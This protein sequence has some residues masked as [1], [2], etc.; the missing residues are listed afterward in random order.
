MYTTSSLFL[1]TLAQVGITHAFVNWGSDHP[2]LLEDLERQRVEK[3]ETEPK[4]VTCPNEMV[5]LSAAQGYT[6]VTGKP[7]AV[8]VHV[9]VGTQALAGAVHNVNRGRAPVLIY[10]GSSP[11]SA[12]GELK[13]SRNEW[14]H[15]MQDVH[16]QPAILRQYMRYTAQ[17]NSPAN[18][19]HLVRRALQIATSDPKGPV[20]LWGRREVMEQEIDEGLLKV[21]A[22]MLKWPSVEPCALSHSAAAI[23]AAALRQAVNPLLITSHAGRNTNVFTSLSAL[24]S[25][26]GMP[27][28]VPCPAVLNTPF[29]YALYVGVGHLAPGT[30]TT[31]LKDADVILVLDVELPW[32]PMN[33]DSNGDHE[34]PKEDARVFVI[35]GGDPLK[36]NIGMY[37]VDAEMVCRADAE[38][39]LGQI[40]EAI[41]HS[42]STEGVIIAESAIVQARTR[43]ME[44]MHSEWV[45]K[46]DKAESFPTSLTSSIPAY[47]VPQ[48]I[49]AL[50][51][52]V[53]SGTP[54]GG[55]HTLML[56]ESISN[57]PLVWSH[58]RP[59]VLGGM[60]GSGGSSLGWALGASVGAFLGGKVAEKGP[61]KQGYEL[62]ASIVGDGTF[63]FGVPA[64]AFWM[65]RKYQTPFLTVILN[66][67]GWKS[68][69]L[70]MLGVYPSGHGSKV[71]G[72]QLTVG[73]GPDMPD[74]AQ[75]AVAASGGWA[76]G[77]KVDAST[78]SEGKNPKDALEEVIAE[79]VRVVVQEGRCAVID[80]VLESI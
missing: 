28:F 20:Y 42:D 59:E 52:A 40:V 57:Y 34:R 66:N 58:M 10:A 5:A 35:D 72:Q 31:L 22:P 77:R 61:G 79:A 2:A 50:R 11:F 71:L 44:K 53:I 21:P 8:I 67:G 62:V 60:I 13:G 15:W 46:L 54:S 26:I 80:C 47:T 1:N 75:I 56:N 48:V 51:R 7:A 23:I 30:Q 39:A 36:E 41:Q 9:D 6:Q 49:S 43:E 78:I 3:G 4:I 16:D 76:W 27:V 32:I 74:Y 73:F 18:L 70:S 63:L 24:C 55:A 65:A 45:A 64:S 68:P 33:K 37:H 69:K 17:I 12:E 25:L 14:I 19:P 38:V 29:S